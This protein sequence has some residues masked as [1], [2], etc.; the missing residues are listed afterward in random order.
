LSPVY[1]IVSTVN[2]PLLLVTIEV[3]SACTR[4]NVLDAP[5]ATLI[6]PPLIFTLVPALTTPNLLLSPVAVARGTDTSPSVTSK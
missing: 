6:T 5:V 4:P 3:P 2:K 1:V